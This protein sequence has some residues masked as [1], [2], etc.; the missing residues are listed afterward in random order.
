MK[1]ENAGRKMM[2]AAQ[3]VVIIF[4][5]IVMV[6]PARVTRVHVSHI[7]MYVGTINLRKFSVDVANCCGSVEGTN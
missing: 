1:G 4:L 5:L 3:F 2:I 7:V 6:Y